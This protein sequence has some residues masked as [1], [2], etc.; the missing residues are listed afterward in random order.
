MDK[1]T[2][3]EWHGS[4]IIL[5]LLC[6]FVITIPLAV[7]YFTSKLLTIETQVPD[8]SKLSDYLRTRK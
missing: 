4:W 6:F 8:G 2:R 5:V 1:V 3:Y 7:V